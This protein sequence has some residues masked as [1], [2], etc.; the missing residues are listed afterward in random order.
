MWKT[1]TNYIESLFDP[2]K[3]FVD[4]TVE[5]EAERLA[6]FEEEH[7]KMLDGKNDGVYTFIGEA[8]S[9]VT[10]PY[11]LAGYFFGRGMLLSCYF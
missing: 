4:V 7:W 9:F 2:D 5:N 6:K 3:S 1:G 10:D 11:Y 8:A